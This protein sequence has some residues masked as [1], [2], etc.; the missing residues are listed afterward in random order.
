MA[1]KSHLSRSVAGILISC[2]LTMAPSATCD[3]WF[4]GKFYCGRGDLEY[5]KLLDISRRMFSPDPEFQNVSMLYTPEWNGLVE[6]P[7]WNAWWVQ[8][9]Y[10][11]TYCALPF[12]Q[13]PYLTFLQNSQDLWF[14]QMGDG[15]RKEYHDWVAPDGCLCDAARP[16]WIVYKQ[17]DGRIDIHDWGMEFTAAGLLLQSELL[18]SERDPSKTR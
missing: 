7:T 4:A 10:G 17:G 9:S 3:D 2:V 15:K 16:G 8:N 14:D 1:H 18:L 6:G 11:P 12:Y 13:E 5:L